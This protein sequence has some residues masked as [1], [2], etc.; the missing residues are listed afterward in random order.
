MRLIL[1]IKLLDNKTEVETPSFHSPIAIDI[2]LR[3]F[4]IFGSKS[5]IRVITR[6]RS[7]P[8]TLLLLKID[9]YKL[10]LNQYT[11]KISQ[12]INSQFAKQLPKKEIYITISF[13]FTFQYYVK[14]KNYI[15]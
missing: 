10:H 6:H 7:L 11:D 1:T 12:I 8:P 4:N 13:L 15:V 14:T 3:Y 9:Q 5:L 2:H